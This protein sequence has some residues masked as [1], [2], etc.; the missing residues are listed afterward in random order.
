MQNILQRFLATR[1][2]ADIL[3]LLGDSATARSI[4]GIP[5]A[6]T[7]APATGTLNE[8]VSALE[9]RLIRDTLARTNNN[10]SETARRL[11]ITRRTLRLKMQKYQL[12]G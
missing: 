7:E 11:H 3:A 12:G 1:Q 5:E 10:K 8:A 2:L 9:K 6:A 4:S